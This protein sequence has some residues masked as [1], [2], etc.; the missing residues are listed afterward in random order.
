LYYGFFNLKN[1][2]NGFKKKNLKSYP[3]G[4]K[5]CFYSQVKMFA[6]NSGKQKSA[7]SRNLAEAIWWQPSVAR[8]CHRN[9]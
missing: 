2:I 7:T 6:I 4:L 3:F 1:L 9:A 5:I 8:R